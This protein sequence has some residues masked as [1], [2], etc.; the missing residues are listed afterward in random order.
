MEVGDPLA[1]LGN[2]VQHAFQRKVTFMGRIDNDQEFSFLH[3]K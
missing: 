2:D 3:L 1:T